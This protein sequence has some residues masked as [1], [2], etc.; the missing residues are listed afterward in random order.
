MNA[1][2][3]ARPLSDYDSLLG[4]V[5]ATHRHSPPRIAV[6][7]IA[8]RGLGAGIP[9]SVLRAWCISRGGPGISFVAK[10]RSDFGQIIK[11]ASKRVARSSSLNGR[12]QIRL[13]A[14]RRLVTYLLSP[15][16]QTAGLS[17]ERSVRARQALAILGAE[18]LSRA[19]EDG[20]DSILMSA[21][22]LAVEM[23]CSRST[24]SSALRA[25]ESAGWIRKKKTRAGSSQAWRL[26]VLPNSLDAIAWAHSDLINS[27]AEGD[28]D[29]AFVEAFYLAAHPAV[30]YGEQ[31]A[32]VGHYAWLVGLCDE[33][34]IDPVEVGMTKRTTPRYRCEWLAAVSEGGTLTE[35]LDAHGATTNAD[36]LRDVARDAYQS[37]KEQR[38]ADLAAVRALRTTVRESLAA[39]LAAHPV[40]KVQTS[41]AQRKAWVE[42]MARTVVETGLPDEMRRDFAAALAS[43][44]VVTKYGYSPAV[45]EKVSRHIAGLPRLQAAA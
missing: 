13:T 17:T 42:V 35:G 18:F 4:P 25:A 2:S 30:S 38:L 14:S 3:P 10:N 26:S 45:A 43:K 1:T 22:W 39:L 5:T 19:V 41:A 44:M 8:E 20:F 40:P 21:N 11:T 27:L 12:A 9:T 24:A 37:A 36:A 15:M 31:G 33:A 23:G 32:R 16:P 7:A 6:R 28:V 29:N 34:G